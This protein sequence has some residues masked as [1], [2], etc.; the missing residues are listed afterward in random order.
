MAFFG[1][2]AMTPT[3]KRLIKICHREEIRIDVEIRRQKL[4]DLKYGI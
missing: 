2:F 3:L 1:F 4:Y